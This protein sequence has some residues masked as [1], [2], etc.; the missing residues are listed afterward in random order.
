MKM[1]HFNE[2][3]MLFNFFTEIEDNVRNFRCRI[4]ELSENFADYEN[5]RSQSLLID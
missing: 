3:L 1:S 4:Q 2:N 5:L